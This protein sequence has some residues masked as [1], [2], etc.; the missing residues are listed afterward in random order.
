MQS[1]CHCR[2]DPVYTRCISFRHSQ[3]TFLAGIQ[4]TLSLD[5]HLHQR[6]Q[7][8]RMCR[9]GILPQ[10]TD[11]AGSLHK[12]LRSRLPQPVRIC[13]T[14]N[15]C[16]CHRSQLL[17]NSQ[18]SKSHTKLQ[19]R[20][21]H[22]S[23]LVHMAH[24]EMRA[25]PSF[26]LRT[27]R[28]HTRHKQC[29]HCSHHPGCQP[30]KAAHKYQC[31]Y[32]EWLGRDHRRIAQYSHKHHTCPSQQLHILRSRTQRMQWYCLHQCRRDPPSTG[33]TS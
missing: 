30:H 25:K 9:L 15:L 18:A 10:R 29:C 14:D 21:R 8:S 23:C 24:S 27:V 7:M 22:R 12:L 4:C 3:H 1:C 6:D 16:S 13:L 28:D 5:P 2:P 11:Q 26:P 33:C 17:R 32:M 31:H 19:D 20:H